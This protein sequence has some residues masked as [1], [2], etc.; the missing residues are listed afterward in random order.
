MKFRFLT[1]TIAAFLLILPSWAASDYLLELDGIP[2][3][4][5]D[6]QR[7][8]A[9]EIQSFSFGASNSGTIVGGGG[10]AGKV[11]FSDITF[12]KN[13]DKSSPILYLHCAQG[14]HIPKATLYV[15]KSGSD[16]PVEYY[17]ITLSDVLVTSV[18]T[19]GGGGLPMESLS[20]NF[21]KI[22][23]SYAAQKPDGS[24]ESPV[25]SGWNIATNMPL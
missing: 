19:S 13:L 8:G 14:K 21:A 11:S 7:P 25:K 6:A 18:Q 5:I 1:S 10:G 23:F 15:R 17:V 9:I 4:S 12:S 22:E 16:K 3:E 2:G 20:L 24:L